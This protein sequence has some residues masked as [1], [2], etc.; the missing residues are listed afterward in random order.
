MPGNKLNSTT[1]LKFIQSF[2]AFQHSMI[3]GLFCLNSTK[4]LCKF[5]FD[6]VV[7]H[8]MNKRSLG[9][10]YI[11]YK[12][13]NLIDKIILCTSQFDRVVD[14]LMNKRIAQR[15]HFC[16]WFEFYQHLLVIFCIYYHFN[17]CNVTC[18]KKELW[19]TQN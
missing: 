13:K 4:I 1:Q 19:T 10:A 16:K 5:Q 8:L 6:R 17:K 18:L 11:L 2:H 12:W 14:H 3:R 9:N 7:Y 15:W